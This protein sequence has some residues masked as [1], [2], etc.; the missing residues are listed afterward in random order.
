MRKI[1]IIC[2]LASISILINAQENAQ[3]KITITPEVTSTDGREVVEYDGML[4]ATNEPTVK[5]QVTIEGCDSIESVL[6]CQYTFNNNENI[7]APYTLEEG[8]LIIDDI[9]VPLVEGSNDFTFKLS[10]KE[11][12]KEDTVLAENAATIIVKIYPKPDFQGVTAPSVF[13]FYKESEELSWTAYGEGGGKWEYSWTSSEDLTSNDESFVLPSITNESSSEK[14]VTVTLTATNYAPDGTTIWDNY[15][16]NWTIKILP[17]TVVD[18]S[19]SPN[20]IDN[21][22]KMFQGDSWNLAVYIEGGSSDGWKIEWI[23][24]DNNNLLSQEL[25]Y[26]VT[27]EY[28]ES[29]EDKHIILHVTNTATEG[30]SLYDMVFHYYA[31]FY[32][33]PQI[34]FSASYPKDVMDGEL[35]QMGVKIVNTPMAEDYVIYCEWDKNENDDSYLFRASNSGNADGIQDVVTV[36]CTFGLV[37]SNARCN[38]FEELSHTFMV[39]PKPTVNYISANENN[40]STP[41]KLFQDG[42]WVFSVITSGGYQTGW[43][44][45][46]KDEKGNE[47]GHGENYTMKC[48]ESYDGVQQKHIILT[49]TNQAPNRE[50]TWFEHSYNYY[51]SFYPTP[52]AEF[53]A[54]YPQD[55]QD[56]EKIQ[57]GVNLVGKALNDYI[58]SYEWEGSYTSSYLYEAENKNDVHGSKKTVTV[59]CTFGLSNSDAIKVQE[60]SH[61]F[62]VWP[63]PSVLYI[64]ANENDSSTPYK[65]FQDGKWEFTVDT[66][67]G[68]Q[69]GWKIIW[70]DEKGNELG[71][72]EKYT[73]KCDKPSDEVQQKHIILTITNQ[74]PNREGNWFEHSYNYY[75]SFYPAPIV[76]FDKEYPKDIKHGDE[77]PMSLIV[78]D[79]HGNPAEDVFGLSYSWNHGQ[80]TKASYVYVGENKDNDDGIKIVIPVEC[81]V[82]L[83]GT[84]LK[85]IYQRET[86]FT[87]WPEPEVNADE[88]VDVFGCGNLALDVSLYVKGGKKNGWAYRWTMNDVAQ[89]V[90]TNNYNA[91]LVCTS[92]QDSLVNFYKV[93]AINTC[94]GKVWFDKEYSFKA[95]VYPVPIVPENIVVF[96]VNRGVEATTGIREGNELLLSCSDCYGGYPTGWTYMWTK[97]NMTLGTTSKVTTNVNSAY[98][99]NDKNSEYINLYR[100]SVANSHDNVTLKQQDYS[101][102]LRV[103]CKPKTPES[104]SKKGSGVSGTVVTTTSLSDNDLEGLEYYLIFGYRDQNGEMHDLDSQRQMAPGVVRWSNKFP[105]SVINNASNTFYV[106]ALWKYSDGVEITSG[107]R[108]TDRVDELWDGS[109]Y[110]GTTRSVIANKTA[111]SYPTIIESNDI[112]EEYY[113][114]DGTKVNNPSKGIN[115]VR[116]SDGRVKKVMIK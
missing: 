49:I 40:S 82:S 2:F 116:M 26:I 80:S 54:I 73:L 96:D 89:S 38:S 20:T 19:V 101:K 37:N 84:D 77:V 98:S 29:I 3:A 71:Q 10:I 6:T 107:L 46:W 12:G 44:I 35:I 63:K 102:E 48:D 70:K 106:Y 91:N 32:P 15:S 52:I 100:C 7:D 57:M 5:Y 62:V 30:N 105:E 18:T 114:L 34:D 69:T 99:G 17:T 87:V 36:I 28:T 24:G 86:T 115:I 85:Q 58:I 51:A 65:Q 43:K 113:S 25:E 110:L 23:D 111:I 50:D 22:Y 72:G 68:Y 39:W 60:L 88:I 42:E 21:P 53:T 47:L 93:R 41:Y 109:S 75:A 112:H 97:D 104:I 103:Y 45:V 11:K 79:S 74:A 14:E 31:R 33:I 27:G 56:G 67:G 64:S 66:F 61:T 92:G 4:C 55:V 81:T 94:D 59:K 90:V 108:M 13:V 8:V 95:V 9:S 78:R 16:E 83:K 1:A 76:K